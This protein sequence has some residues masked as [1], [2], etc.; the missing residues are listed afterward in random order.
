[1]YLKV[2]MKVQGSLGEFIFPFLSYLTIFTP[3]SHFLFVSLV[4]LNF[5]EAFNQETRVKVTLRGAEKSAENL[6]IPFL[7]GWCK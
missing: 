6:D 7:I 5:L 3:Q 1:M 4:L 2:L